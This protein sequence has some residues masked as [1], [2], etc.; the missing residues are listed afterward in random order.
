[1]RSLS[2]EATKMSVQVSISS[3]GLLQRGTVWHHQQLVLS[4]CAKYSS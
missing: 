4:C 1:V 2:E 3:L